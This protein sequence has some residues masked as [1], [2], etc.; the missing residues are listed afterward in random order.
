MSGASE[1]L[2]APSVT[3]EWSAEFLKQISQRQPEAEH[4]IIRDG[5]GF[6]QKKQ[7]DQIPAN[8]HLINLP[9]YSPDWVLIIIC[10]VEQTIPRQ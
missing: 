1:F 8:V 10:F 6:H 7:L 4:A 3:L 9:P 2:C 5:A